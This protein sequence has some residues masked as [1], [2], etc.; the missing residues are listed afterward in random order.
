MTDQR[1]KRPCARF[2][3][4]GLVDHGQR[5]CQRCAPE[6]R[7]REY[8]ADRPSAARR[9]Y[10]HRW[11]IYRRWY[12]ARNPLCVRCQAEGRIEPAT[13]VDHIKPVDGPYDPGFWDGDNHQ[14]LCHV[15]HS[16]KTATE[17]GGF[18]H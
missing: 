17:D 5:Y 4:G 15:H 10:G 8:D 11:R 1:P 16:A 7:P 2:G 9:G 3:C 14:A 6:P 12:L 18:G 13:D